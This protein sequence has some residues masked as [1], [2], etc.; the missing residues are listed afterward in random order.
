[1]DEGLPRDLEDELDRIERVRDQDPSRA[2]KLMARVRAC[3]LHIDLQADRC[4]QCRGRNLTKYGP[5]AEVDREIE[6]RGLR[7]LAR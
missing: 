1:L 4:G 5:L 2:R 7:D 3:R 6:R